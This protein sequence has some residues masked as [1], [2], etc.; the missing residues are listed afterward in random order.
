MALNVETLFRLKS[1]LLTS[2]IQEKNQPLYQVINLLIDGVISGLAQVNTSLSGSGSG[3]G[4]GGL[5][6]ASYLT[7]LNETASLPNSRALLAGE[8]IDF[9]DSVAGQRTI[10]ANVTVA[11]VTVGPDVEIRRFT[12]PLQKGTSGKV[13]IRDTFTSAQV[14]APV[15]ISQVP[16][17][18]SEGG[19]VQFIGIVTDIRLMSVYWMAP[20]GA[21]PS[22]KIDCLIGATQ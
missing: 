16:T 15:F 18:E 12:I 17:P 11:Q 10:N 22:V 21:P 4:S 7:I 1:Q 9:D 8:N 13:V 3:S 19:F 6:G 14:G 2:G 5:L 20:F